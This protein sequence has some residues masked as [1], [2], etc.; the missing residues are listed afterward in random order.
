MKKTINDLNLTAEY[1]YTYINRL[2]TEGDTKLI[3]F[4]YP[5]KDGKQNSENVSEL[6][7]LQLTLNRLKTA[8]EI[9]IKNI[10]NA[11]R[12]WEGEL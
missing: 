11:T 5:N 7:I 12:N 6:M 8:L 4:A 1:L 10:T 9:T 2:N 3:N